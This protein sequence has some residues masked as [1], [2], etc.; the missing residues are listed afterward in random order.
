MLKVG[1]NE[2]ERMWFAE[3]C[4]CVCECECVRDRDGFR[5][6]QVGD[7]AMGEMFVKCSCL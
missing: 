1:H 5:V 3:V 2:Y 7:N 6:C 4:V